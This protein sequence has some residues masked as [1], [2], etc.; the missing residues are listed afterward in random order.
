MVAIK[1]KKQ[2]HQRITFQQIARM[3][4]VTILKL[5]IWVVNSG[6]S[7]SPSQRICDENMIR[8]YPHQS[9]TEDSCE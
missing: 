7:Y 2:N 9:C 5:F 3:S 8:E 1:I 4:L 6:P